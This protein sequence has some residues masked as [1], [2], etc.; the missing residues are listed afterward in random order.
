MNTEC[1]VTPIEL[2]ADRFEDIAIS[3]G[4]RVGDFLVVS[5][6]AASGDGDDPVPPGDF[7]AQ[8]HS[9]FRN[10]RTVLEAG[11]SSLENVV[12]VTIFVTD[13]SHYE[14]VVRMRRQYF[15]PPYP[16]DTIVEVT[17]LAR[18]ELMIEIEALAA[19]TAEPVR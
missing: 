1:N 3:Q 5:G 4:F 9:A 6:Q 2:E 19:A 17:A 13:M 10:L 8:A 11:G 16:A 14:T 7:E 15:S 18:P 12:K